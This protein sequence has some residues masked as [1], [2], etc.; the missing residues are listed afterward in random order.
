MN[1]RSKA[2]RTGVF[3][4]SKE[5]PNDST[6]DRK[7]RVVAIITRMLYWGRR[8][9]LMGCVLQPISASQHGIPKVCQTVF[10]FDAAKIQPIASGMPLRCLK[11]VPAKPQ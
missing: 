1:C 10:G 3:D 2:Y 4:Q 8:T 9:A 6:R 5:R 7:A 11:K